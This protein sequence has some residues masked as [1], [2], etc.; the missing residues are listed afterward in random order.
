M[1]KIVWIVALLSLLIGSVAAVMATATAAPPSSVVNMSTLDAKLN[2]IIGELGNPGYGL[3]ALNAND[4]GLNTKL[5]TITN[6][7][8]DS[9]YGLQAVS[10]ALE[11]IQK[12]MLRVESFGP[13][14]LPFEGH[15]SI[16]WVYPNVRHVSLSIV[17]SWWS[18]DANSY[19]K[20]T[21]TMPGSGG[22]ISWGRTWKGRDALGG[23]QNIEFDAQEWDLTV[24]DGGN[25]FTHV[26]YTG[27]VTYSEAPTTYPYPTP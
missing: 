19:I 3:P 2:T 25:D 7:L 22:W 11:D 9:E 12:N 13:W 10:D 4:S 8:N 6:A 16:H 21:A 5:D 20:L 15:S 17:P 27:T 14:W 23:A 1:K 24:H 18:E 26:N